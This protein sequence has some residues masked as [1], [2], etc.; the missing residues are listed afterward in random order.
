MKYFALFSLI[1]FLL[2]CD[3]KEAVITADPPKVE[4]LPR[5]TTWEDTAYTNAVR[6]NTFTYNQ[7]GN[8][9]QVTSPLAGTGAEPDYF[10]YDSLQRLVEHS[11]LFTYQYLY[12]GTD[13]LPYAAIEIWPYDQ[14][15]SLAFSYDQEQ[16]IIKVVSDYIHSDDPDQD[17][18][19]VP[20]HRE[21]VYAYDSK[22]NLVTD[23][24]AS[25]D[26]NDKPSIYRTNKWWQLI[27][28]DFSKNDLKSNSDYNEWD[29]P[30]KV[31][32]AMFLRLGAGV[33]A[34]AK[35]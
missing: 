35:N 3:K 1:F 17:S 33:V 30:G 31:N 27:H 10:T 13:T 26:Y 23:D 21:D 28:L 25:S 12:T 24:L 34:Y 7:Y 6:L 18:T 15:Y 5:I 14:R 16:R 32:T 19:M 22:G 8:P 29:L 2:S 11:S 9:V 4:A 20:T